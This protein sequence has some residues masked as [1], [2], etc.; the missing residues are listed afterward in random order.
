MLSALSRILCASAI[1]GIALFIFSSDTFAQT[2]VS[3]KSVIPDF[4]FS[5]PFPDLAITDLEIKGGRA[6]GKYT[7]VVY[8]WV[9]GFAAILALLMIV[10]GGY[11]WMVGKPDK[12]RDLIKNALIGLILALGSYILLHTINPALV[13]CNTLNLTPIHEL[14]FV[15]REIK[16]S[17]QPVS[18]VDVNTRCTQNS[19]CTSNICS[20]NNTCAGVTTSSSTPFEKLKGNCCYVQYKNAEAI[21]KSKP[22]HGVEECNQML[23]QEAGIARTPYPFFCPDVANVTLSGPEICWEAKLRTISIP[24]KQ[25]ARENMTRSRYCMGGTNQKQGP[26]VSTGGKNFIPK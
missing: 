11:A 21:M 14:E 8:R 7:C 20:P 17:T 4:N 1:C 24:E 9:V 12:G 22:V 19:D 6:L 15:V 25:K 10:I 16:L 26:G 13:A 18:H 5:V 3:S 23:S 2:A